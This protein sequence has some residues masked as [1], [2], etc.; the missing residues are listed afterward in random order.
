MKSMIKT[1]HFWCIFPQ[2]LGEQLSPLHSWLRAY[3]Q[4]SQSARSVL[5]SKKAKSVNSSELTVTK[6]S[7]NHYSLYTCVVPRWFV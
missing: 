1:E 4:P 6:F 5:A 3:F 7:V 2:F